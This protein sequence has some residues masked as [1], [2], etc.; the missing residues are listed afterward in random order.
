MT[1]HPRPLVSFVT[2]FY[3]TAQYL[4]ECIE[5]V[6]G[7]TYQNW[8]YHLVN[9]CSTDGSQEI[10][11]KYAALDPRIKLTTNAEFL[12]QVP[13]YNHALR[14]VSSAATFVKMVQADDWLFPD[15]TER[16][17]E[18]ARTDPDI[19][20]VSAYSLRHRFIG[21]VGLPYP[22]HVTPGETALRLHLME[23]K[24]VVG[25]PTNV[26]YRA[27]L[28]RARTTFFDEKS[29]LEDLEI[30]YELLIGRKLGFVHQVLT[31]LRE[32]NPSISVGL[33]AYNPWP[34]HRLILLRKYGPRLLDEQEYAG[35]LERVESDYLKFLGYAKLVGR[36]KQF[37]DYQREGFAEM[38]QTL[39][40]GRLWREAFGAALDVVANPKLTWDRY[41]NR[42]T[43]AARQ[44][45]RAL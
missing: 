24:T 42:R 6:L 1:G 2:P 36:P 39:P 25:T 27:D 4:A 29:M 7:Q 31:Y 8:E 34:L 45:G 11:Q 33:L 28:V 44:A 40:T 35:C 30:C 41:Q 10:A 12:D 43:R 5:S 21:C 18:L 15:C 32:D 9:N 26:L 19:A 20:I 14:Q 16:M 22:S 17:V 13:N 23:G 38:G 3:N 37:W